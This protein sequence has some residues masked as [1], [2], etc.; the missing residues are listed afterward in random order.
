MNGNAW[1][2][3]S[4]HNSILETIQCTENSIPAVQYLLSKEYKVLSSYTN[5]SKSS[6]KKGSPNKGSPQKGMKRSAGK[7]I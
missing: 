7:Y 6:P 5:I 3:L 4:I 2:Q 1:K